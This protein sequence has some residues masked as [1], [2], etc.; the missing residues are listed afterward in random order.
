MRNLR[1][2]SLELHKQS[3]GEI[4]INVK[5]PVEN[6]YDLSLAYSTGVAD[7][8]KEIYLS[9]EKMFPSQCLVTNTLI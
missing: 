2:T 5:V 4:H 8:C 3:Q 1:E 6:A 9:P 7:P